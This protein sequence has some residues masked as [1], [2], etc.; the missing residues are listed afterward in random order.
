MG[1]NQWTSI[2]KHIPTGNPPTG[3]HTTLTGIVTI[4]LT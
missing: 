1:L 3:S 2:K 4:R